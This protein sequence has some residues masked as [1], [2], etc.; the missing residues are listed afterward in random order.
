MK[1][2]LT[3]CTNRLELYQDDRPVT[4][5][6]QSPKTTTAAKP[7]RG[8]CVLKGGFLIAISEDVLSQAIRMA[9]ENDTSALQ[10]LQNAGKIAVT[11]EGMQVFLVKAHW[12]T[13]EVRLK[14]RTEIFW[15]PAEAIDCES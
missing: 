4:T 13:N 9:V 15:T 11:T 3:D 10:E 1:G 2:K 8:E 6:Q 12:T 7:S 14:G 5:A